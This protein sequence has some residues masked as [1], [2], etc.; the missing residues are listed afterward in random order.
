[1]FD[2]CLISD[3]G[4][5]DDQWSYVL[6]HWYPRNVYVIGSIDRKV[7]PFRDAILIG[8]AEELP[9]LPIVALQPDNARYMPGTISLPGFEHPGECIYLF[10]NDHTHLCSDQMGARVP[11]SLVFIPTASHD[12]MYSWTA[13][14][15]SLYDRAIKNG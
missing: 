8:S 14:A 15:V 4:R 2:V 7:K 5:W 12:E 6:S 10:G 13:G 1:M 9:N 11:D 3:T